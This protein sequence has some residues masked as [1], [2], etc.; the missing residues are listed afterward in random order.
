MIWDLTVIEIE[1]VVEKQNEEDRGAA[2]RAGLIAAMIGNQNRKKGQRLLQ[3][4][5]FVRM[6][7]DYMTPEAARAHLDQWARETGGG[8]KP[9]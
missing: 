5:D 9:K 3:P 8:E 6:P 2:L 4:H 7:D 1:A